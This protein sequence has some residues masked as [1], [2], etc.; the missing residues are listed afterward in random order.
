M[1]KKISNEEFLNKINNLDINNEYQVLEKY[2]GRQVKI[3]FRHKKCGKEFEMDPNHFYRGQRCPHCNKDNL[4]TTNEYK[5]EIKGLVGEEYELLEEYKNSKTPIL[6]KHCK[7]GYEYKV[8]PINF[9]A[10]YRCPNCSHNKKKT[11][12]SFSN[13]VNNLDSEYLVLG[14]YKN[15]KTKILMKH[16]KCGKE[17]EMRPNDFITGHR[18]PYCSNLPHKS[19]GVILIEKYLNENKLQYKKEY[20]FNDCKYYKTLPFDFCVFNNDNSIKLLIEFDGKQHFYPMKSFGGEKEFEKT[21]KRDSIKND[22]C[23]KNKIKLLRIN[24]KEIDF[25]EN[26]LKENIK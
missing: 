4:K 5:N 21:K 13:E 11:T 18:C 6:M 2:K 22:Y 16:K 23:K 19:K 1:S 24:Y 14:E 25:I 26:I 8:S 20:R 3:K 17:F 12:K 7:C 9:K 15:N 10:G